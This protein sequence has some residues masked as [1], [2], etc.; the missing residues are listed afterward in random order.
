MVSM[1]AVPNCCG[2][3]RFDRTG[4]F[5]ATHGGVFERCVRRLP[6]HSLPARDPIRVDE[7]A[8]ALARLYAVR[9]TILL[10]RLAH[11]SGRSAQL[12]VHPPD[13]DE[14]ATTP[15]ST[16]TGY[17]DKWGPSCLKVRLGVFVQ[18]P[19]YPRRVG[20]CRACSRPS[21]SS[22]RPQAVVHARRRSPRLDSGWP[23][24]SLL[25]GSPMRTTRFG[26]FRGTKTPPSKRCDVT[27]HPVSRACRQESVLRL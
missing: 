10:S 26:R 7:H 14:G 22:C 24:S 4:H 18:R 2:G 13:Y 6:G 16:R 19:C 9:R 20:A 12:R 1:Q 15:T 25:D 21:T 11:E 23:S 27:P 5:Y 17:A 3:C 8:G